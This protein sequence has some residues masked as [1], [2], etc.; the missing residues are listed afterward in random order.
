MR[1]EFD[2][3]IEVLSISTSKHGDKKVR[4]AHLTNLARLA[5]CKFQ[6][7]NQQNSNRVVTLEQIENF[8]LLL[9]LSG[10]TEY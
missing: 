2:F 4:L 1:T 10:M 7:V 6:E 5:K 3:F 8:R 9:K